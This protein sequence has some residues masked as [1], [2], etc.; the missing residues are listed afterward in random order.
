MAPCDKVTG[1]PTKPNAKVVRGKS[2][3]LILKLIDQANRKK[4]LLPLG[5]CAQ[6][7]IQALMEST[8]RR[9]T[10]DL[11]KIRSVEV[12]RRLKGN[13]LVRSW[14]DQHVKF[15][16]DEIQS[17]IDFEPNNRSELNDPCIVDLDNFFSRLKSKG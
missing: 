12:S 3:K 13:Q 17:Q 9:L 8:A 11:E 10:M 1:R 14:S 7:R 5:S 16:A 4:Q 2:T 15:V 6:Y